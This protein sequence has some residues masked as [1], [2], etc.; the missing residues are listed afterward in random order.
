MTLYIRLSVGVSTRCDVCGEEL[1]FCTSDEDEN[2]LLVGPCP[3]CSEKSF[4]LGAE[5]ALPQ[6][7]HWKIDKLF[8]PLY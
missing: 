7:E 8:E 5:W 2:T 3:K 1:T 6:K 4:R